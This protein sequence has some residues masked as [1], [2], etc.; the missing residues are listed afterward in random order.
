MTTPQRIGAAL[1]RAPWWL[2]LLLMLAVLIAGVVFD[3]VIATLI[4]DRPP[5]YRS[6]ELGYVCSDASHTETP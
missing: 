6:S 2:L 1:D 5:V 3:L 4:C